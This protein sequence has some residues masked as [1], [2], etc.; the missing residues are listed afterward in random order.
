MEIQRQH[1]AVREDIFLRRFNWSKN[2]QWMGYGRIISDDL[3]A[4]QK[5]F[6]E[7]A[8][9]IDPLDHFL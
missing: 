6:S 9:V 8:L 3:T 4:R 1:H 5:L 7:S 2:D